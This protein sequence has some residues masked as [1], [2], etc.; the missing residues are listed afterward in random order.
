MRYAAGKRAGLPIKPI[1][2][3]RLGKNH[4]EPPLEGK[5]WAADVNYSIRGNLGK[6]SWWMRIAYNPDYSHGGE[7]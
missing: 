2:R 6:P 5:C 3:K 7:V 4:V 1:A